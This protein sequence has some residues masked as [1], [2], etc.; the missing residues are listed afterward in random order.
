M[1]LEVIINYKSNNSEKDLDSTLKSI[2]KFRANPTTITICLHPSHNFIDINR[3]K[4][5][6][7]SLFG[8]KTKWNIHMLTEVLNHSDVINFAAEKSKEKYYLYMNAGYELKDKIMDC[9]KKQDVFFVDPEDEEYNGFLCN[10]KIHKSLLGF[11][12]K[13]TLMEKIEIK[14]EEAR[15]FYENAKSKSAESR[16]DNL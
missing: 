12:K 9:I 13:Y 2:K 8:K 4:Q 7:A 15:E 1:S 5:K 16:S 6:L 14:L 11:G 3:Y 10:T